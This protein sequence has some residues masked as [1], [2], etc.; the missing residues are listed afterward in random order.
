MVMSKNSEER[1]PSSR[2]L[3]ARVRDRGSSMTR[4]GERE[5]PTVVR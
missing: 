2:M 5:A 3:Q 4:L 1:A